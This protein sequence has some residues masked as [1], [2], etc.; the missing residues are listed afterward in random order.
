MV[1]LRLPLAKKQIVSLLSQLPAA[2]FSYLSNLSYELTLFPST[3]S[4]L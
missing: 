3:A 4:I 1:L 2:R